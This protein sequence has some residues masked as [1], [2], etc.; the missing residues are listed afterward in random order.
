MQ[1][2]A[3]I[4]WDVI[5]QVGDRKPTNVR[6]DIKMEDLQIQD[7]KAA[8]CGLHDVRGSLQASTVYQFQ[9]IEILHCEL[10]PM[11][12][13]IEPVAAGALEVVVEDRSILM[14]RYEETDEEL[15]LP[16]KKICIPWVYMLHAEAPT[17]ENKN[18]CRKQKS[19][20]SVPTG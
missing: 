13:P 19:V 6:S 5:R 12:I 9:S 14:L 17:Q 7:R 4:P 11:L 15:G 10:G 18:V 3:N 16:K 1:D 20:Q 2:P 8:S